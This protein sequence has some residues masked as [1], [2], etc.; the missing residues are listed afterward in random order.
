M[1]F[2]AIILLPAGLIIG[3][4]LAGVTYRLPR[5]EEFVHGRSRCPACGRALRVIDLIPIVSFIIRRGR[6]AQCGAPISW[7]YPA[8][9]AAGFLIAFWAILAGSGVIV[10]IHAALGWTLLALTV[11]DLEHLWLPDALTLPLIPGGLA[12]AYAFPGIAFAWHL[13]GVVAGFLSLWLIAVLYR[14]LRGRTGLGGGDP[15]LLAAA[16]A[17]VSIYGLPYV[18]LIGAGTGLIYALARGLAGYETRAHTPVPFGP[19]LA[20]GFWITWLYRLPFLSY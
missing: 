6:C 18:L 20:L 17:W 1:A 13:A 9:E 8:I 11:F 14:R 15:K 10:W 12:V 3:S 16:G 2:E 4:F 5:G 19:F 7:R